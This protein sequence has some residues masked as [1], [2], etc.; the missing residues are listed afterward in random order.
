[1]IAKFII[2][3]NKICALKVLLLNAVKIVFISLVIAQPAI[4]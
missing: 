3:V 4:N 1:M 2:S